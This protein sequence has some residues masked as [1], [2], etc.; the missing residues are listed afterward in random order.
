[1]SRKIVYKGGSGRR[2]SMKVRPVQALVIEPPAEPMGTING[3]VPASSYEWNMARALWFYKWEF[4]YLLQLRG[5]HDIRG[6]LE[7]D[8]LVKTRPF[9]T[10]LQVDGGHWHTDSEKE[11]L[12]DTDLINALR[13]RGYQVNFPPKHAVDKDAAV[14][15]DAKRYVATEF[16]RA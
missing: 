5:G 13:E 3:R 14:F 4:F 12:H 7:C 15:E 9:W 10:P 8:F 6:G 11:R 2:A 16:G 1:L